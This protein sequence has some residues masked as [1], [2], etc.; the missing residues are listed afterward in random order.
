MNSF[1]NTFLYFESFS[2]WNLWAK[3]FLV[4]WEGISDVIK[5]GAY[6]LPLKSSFSPSDAQFGLQTRIV[7]NLTQRSSV[8]AHPLSEMV[9]LHGKVFLPT[10]LSNRLAH[11][12]GTILESSKWVEVLGPAELH[13]LVFPCNQGHYF[14]L[15]MVKTI[16]DDSTCY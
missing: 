11:T 8:E 6:F 14:L 7:W 15:M 12:A 13:L 10:S 5:E 4:L 3:Y 9:R 1:Q 16:G 2:G